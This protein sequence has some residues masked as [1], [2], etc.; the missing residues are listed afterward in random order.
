MFSKGSKGN[1]RKKS[2]NKKENSI[3]HAGIFI[4]WTQSNNSKTRRLNEAVAGILSAN[5]FQ[6][7]Y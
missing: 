5:F 4:P 1:I 7:E 6:R 2:S 3:P